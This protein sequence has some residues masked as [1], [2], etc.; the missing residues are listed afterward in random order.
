MEDQ[1]DLNMLL[2]SG[3]CVNILFLSSDQL[4]YREMI[5]E[6]LPKKKKKHTAV[7]VLSFLACQRLLSF[8]K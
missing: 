8:N 5:D 1:S 2:S 7:T 3:G 6:V 4:P